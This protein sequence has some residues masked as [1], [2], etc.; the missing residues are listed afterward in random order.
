MGVTPA[1][2]VWIGPTGWPRLTLFHEVALWCYDNLRQP[3]G[4]QAGRPWEFTDQQAR[5]VAWWFAHDEAGRFLYRRGVIRMC[6]GW[7]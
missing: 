4:P 2:A 5:I 1:H 7:G 3:D 6:K